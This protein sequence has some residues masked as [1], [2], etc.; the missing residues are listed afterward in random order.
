MYE[1]SLQPVLILEVTRCV[2][3]SL[4]DSGMCD[5]KE[6]VKFIRDLSRLTKIR[7]R[8]N[9]SARGKSSSL[10][11]NTDVAACIP[12]MHWEQG[13]GYYWQGY[14]KATEI[15]YSI[16]FALSQLLEFRLS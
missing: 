6:G 11:P 1:S 2:N 5:R 13:P 10:L 8:Y 12:A 7:S 14:N 4:F 9:A 16:G 15:I 3:H